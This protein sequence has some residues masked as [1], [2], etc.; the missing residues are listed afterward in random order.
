MIYLLSEAAICFGSYSGRK[1]SKG[2]M[3]CLHERNAGLATY[4]QNYVLYVWN[5]YSKNLNAI[6][7]AEICINV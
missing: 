6:S 7:A 2:V 3:S 4:L 1:I 5:N